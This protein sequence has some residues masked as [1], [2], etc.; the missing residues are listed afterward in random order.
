M[1]SPSRLTYDINRQNKDIDQNNASYYTYNQNF[2]DDNNKNIIYQN[3]D[4]N[5]ITQ[6]NSFLNQTSPLPFNS[7]IPF[8]E[9]NLIINNSY[10]YQSNNEIRFNRLHSR[11][12]EINSK[13]SK[14]KLDKESFIH[15]KISNTE[16]ILKTNNENCLKKINEIKNNIKSLYNFFDQIKLFTKKNSEETEQILDSFENKFNIRIKE[17]ENKR[18]NLEKKL[19]NLIDTKFKDMKYKI[20]EKSKEKNEEQEDIK[21]K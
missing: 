14:E 9:D 21:D 11:L 7:R 12:D 4:I 10:N 16:I 19:K 13:I 1:S 15:N 2:N 5:N 17:E 20:S 3:Q 18:I 6:N 8:K